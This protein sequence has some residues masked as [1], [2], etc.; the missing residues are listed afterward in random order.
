ME[1]V[2]LYLLKMLRDYAI[3]STRFFTSDSDDLKSPLVPHLC[4]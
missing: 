2:G 3:S 1:L 4:A